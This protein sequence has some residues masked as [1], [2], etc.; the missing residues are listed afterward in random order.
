MDDFHIAVAAI[1]LAHHAQVIT[2][3]LARF[4]HIEGLRCSDWSS[5][6]ASAYYP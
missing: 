6:L 4:N 3:N 5:E 1:A 2:A